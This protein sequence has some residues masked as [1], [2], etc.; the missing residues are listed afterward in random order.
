[1]S[2]Y[3]DY[4]YSLYDQTH[5][6]RDLNNADKSWRWEESILDFINDELDNG[7]TFIYTTSIVSR[8]KKHFDL[9]NANI[10]ILNFHDRTMDLTERFYCEAMPCDLQHLRVIGRVI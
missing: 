10:I 4:L 2:S 9:T 5:K 6:K 7:K 1:M 3:Y 8:I